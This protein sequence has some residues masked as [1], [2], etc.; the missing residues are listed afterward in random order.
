MNSARPCPL[1]LG[2]VSP[3][4]SRISALSLICSARW[5]QSPRSGD[6]RITGWPSR[7][8]QEKQIRERTG[9]KRTQ[10]STGELLACVRTA[11]ER[12]TLAVWY[13]RHGHEKSA[14]REI[15][16]VVSAERRQTTGKQN[17]GT[18]GG[19]ARIIQLSERGERVGECACRVGFG[20]TRGTGPC[21]CVFFFWVSGAWGAW[22]G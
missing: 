16:E 2:C 17:V 1:W 8:V 12:K 10:K 20:P 7:A 9:N 3:S 22:A 21:A 4:L 18:G 5:F 11:L 19:C 6:G 15:G 13:H 14:R